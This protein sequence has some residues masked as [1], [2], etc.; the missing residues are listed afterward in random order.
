M[1]ESA[2]RGSE[3]LEL[4]RDSNVAGQEAL[5]VSA[6]R[7]SAHQCRTG[8]QGRSGSPRRSWSALLSFSLT[9]MILVFV[10]RIQEKIP[11]LS[12]ASLGNIAVVLSIIG[13][14]QVG[15]LRD[16]RRVLA[17]PQG[18]LAAWFVAVAAFSIPFAL[19][20]G[21]AFKSFVAFLT[22]GVLY[23][24]VVVAVRRPRQLLYL[25][26]VFA[27]GAAILVS[28]YV[29]DWLI[30][31]GG[32]TKQEFVAFDRN[33]VALLSVMGIPF[34]LAISVKGGRW[35]WLGFILA[36]FLALGVIATDSRGGFLALVATCSLILIR[37]RFLSSGK[38]IALVGLGVGILLVGGSSEYWN[39]IEAIF[40]SPSEDYNVA[41]RDG[42]VEVWKRGI[43]YFGDNP[44]TG[45][46]MGNFPVAE[47]ASLD[48]GGSTGKW[49]TAHSS[50]VLV[51]AEL[52][53][54]G[55][56][57]FVALLLS[58]GRQARHT[59]RAFRR[60]QRSSL[61]ELSAV[62]DATQYSLVGYAVG[63][64]FLSASFSVSFVFLIAVGA[65]LCL[66]TRS[67]ISILQRVRPNEFGSSGGYVGQR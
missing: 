55:L 44:L 56:I 36:G 14:A 62:A 46:G 39:R 66:L 27:V 1:T 42:R 30:G 2:W 63:G 64:A 26:F 53:I 34:A 15:Y 49:N 60:Q 20:P 47:E 10:G 33:D 19:W 65:C 29:I 51:A 38:K 5:P 12:S 4:G 50:Y 22:I 43:G 18:K 57:I 28:A 9:L 24:V 37:S 59:A 52:G 8:V 17:A 25:T 48:E 3:I 35:L 58:I 23:A 45:V 7:Y 6:A 32:L 16:W 11:G 54:G 21:G 61:A 40:V 41:S 67:E 31:T 13:L